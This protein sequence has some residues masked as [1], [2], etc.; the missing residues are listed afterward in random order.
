MS[1]MRT[2]T[3]TEEQYQ[4][5][6]AV[7]AQ[8]SGAK[9]SKAEKVKKEKRTGSLPKGVTPPHLIK[10]NSY[11]DSVEA[12]LKELPLDDVWEQWAATNPVKPGKMTVDADGKKVRGPPGPSRVT[13]EERAKF[14]VIRQVAMAIAK[15]RKA[16]GE[17][18]TE[19]EH[20]PM[21]DEEKA[22]AKA[23]RAATVAATVAASSGSDSESAAPPKEKKPRKPRTPKA[24]P[25]APEVVAPLPATPPPEE[26]DDEDCMEFA[27]FTLKGKKYLK[28]DGGQCWVRNADGSR[29]KWAGLY[30]GH[31]VDKLDASVPEPALDEN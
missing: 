16:A 7:F 12:S 20:T 1:T 4:A 19:F 3:I 10:W 8:A 18:P 30:R 26:N 31:P 29:G 6:Q 14:K 5:L 27:E 2:I 17:M 15:S 23:T 13:D 9:P 28:L 24:K 11:V 25:A 21:S 22:A